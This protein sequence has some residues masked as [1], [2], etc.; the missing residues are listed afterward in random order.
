MTSSGADLVRKGAADKTHVHTM[1]P[2]FELMNDFLAR[3][4]TLTCPPCVKARG[5]TE[6]DLIDG[7]TVG[8]AAAMHTLILEDA[9]TRRFRRLLPVAA[10]FQSPAA[11]PASR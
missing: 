5:Y 8:G 1:K 11:A 9:A 4:G 3:G 6:D 7:V 10:V 2:M